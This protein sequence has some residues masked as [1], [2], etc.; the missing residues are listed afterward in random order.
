MVFSGVLLSR[1]V[2]GVDVVEGT[3]IDGDRGALWADSPGEGSYSTG[4]AEEMMNDFL[5]ELIITEV[6]FTTF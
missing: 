4:F 1:N 2:E 6:V 3:N 5:V